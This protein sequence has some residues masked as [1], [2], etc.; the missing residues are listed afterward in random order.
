MA[1][2]TNDDNLPLAA[3][4]DAPETP[5]D[6]APAARSLGLVTDP[7]RNLLDVITRMLPTLRRGSRQ[8]A[9]FILAQPQFVVDASLADLARSAALSEP[10]VLRF[11]ASLGCSGFRELKIRLA[12]SLVLGSS[13]APTTHAAL[14]ADDTPRAIAAKIFDFTAASLE[15]TRQSLDPDA[16]DQAVEILALATHIEFFGF[17]ASGIVALDAQQ[18]FPLF[19][20]PCGATQDSHQ[21]L[22]T[23][24]MMQAGDAVV[25][26]SNTGTTLSLI[27]IAKVARERGARVIAITGS[28]SPVSRHADVA[29]IA[30]SL[31]N[32]ELYTPT[33][34]RLSALAVIDIL[35]VSVALRRGEE[36][37][38][39]VSAMKKHLAAIRSGGG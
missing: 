6:A 38:L 7:S 9:E 16:L 13:A 14:S 37:A 28:E 2:M 24:S 12:Q 17:G 33:I 29:L 15:L 20:V 4:Q 8:L 27:E 26:I 22:I 10:T 39:H 5:D 32:T 34:S 19:G 1:S 11:C 30:A 3:A 23:A 36:H 18:K 31:D 21:Q 35:S 25:L